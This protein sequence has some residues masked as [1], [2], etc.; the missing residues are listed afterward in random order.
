MPLAGK[1]N[2]LYI[3]KQQRR[4][5]SFDKKKIAEIVDN[6]YVNA[7]VLYYFGISF[8]DYSEE[9]LE[10]ACVACGLDVETVIKKLEETPQ[11]G[12]NNAPE[13]QEY[14]VRLIVEYLKHAHYLFIKQKLPYIA[15]LIE[16]YKLPSSSG[17]ELARDL[18]FVFP[19]FVEDFIHHIYEEEDTLFKYLIDLTDYLENGKNTGSIYWKME[20]KALQ[21]F[22]MEHEEHDDEM[23]GIRNITDNYRISA[24]TPLALK[25]IFAE[26]RALEDDLKTHAHI[27]NEILFPKALA[28]EREVAEKIQL[29]VKL[30]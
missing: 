6:N 7:S 19:L 17:H 28:L 30:N 21:R 12:E 4:K 20:E 15:R 10:Q 13:L 16:S 3:F 11:K 2:Y 14:P 18:K 29:S 23:R 27:E 25:V 8:F 24:G 26:L 22:A 1:N 9:T 5:L